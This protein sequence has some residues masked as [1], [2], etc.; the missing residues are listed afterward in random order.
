MGSSGCTC[1]CV[2]SLPSALLHTCLRYQSWMLI[3]YENIHV[4]SNIKTYFA[5]FPITHN[6]FDMPSSRFWGGFIHGLA[7]TLWQQCVCAYSEK[8]MKTFRD[9]EYFFLRC[10]RR[11]RKRHVQTYQCWMSMLSG[12]YPPRKLLRHSYRVY[13][14][15][16]IAWTYI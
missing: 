9:V 13:Q 1:A 14:T 10:W 6:T 16:Y 3:R 5:M 11:R 12:K 7:E 4:I 15:K 8:I 2:K